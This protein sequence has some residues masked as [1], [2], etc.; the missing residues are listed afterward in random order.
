MLGAGHNEPATP[1]RS[2]QSSL[3]KPQLTGQVIGRFMTPSEI[4]ELI[5]KHDVR[6][7][8]LQFVDIGGVLHTLWIPVDLLSAVAEEGIHTDGSSLAGMV[9]V[10]K[11]DVKL[12]P[13]MGTFVVLPAQLFPERVARVVCDIYEPESDRP[14]ELDP[15][16][17]LRQA[18]NKARDTLG[19]DTGYY[20]ASEIEFFLLKRDQS[21]ELEL[22]DQGRYL[23]TP[24]ADRGADL[25]LEMAAALR[26]MGVVVEKHHHEV[27]HGK[28]EFNLQYSHAVHMADTIYLVKFLVKQMADQ[29]GL[30]ASFMPKPF[31][32][33]YGCGLHTHVSLIDDD[34][35]QNL[36]ADP[37]AD[38]GLSQTATHFLAG[39]LSHAR[40]LAGITNPSVNSYKR[41]V[42]GWEA[43]VNISW[44]RYNRSVLVRIPPGRG[45]GTRLEYRPTD[46]ACNFYLAFAC[47][48]AAGL[49][50]IQRKLE[51]PAPVEE[52]IYKMTAEERSRRGIEVL[53]GSLGEALAELSADEVLRTGLG[54][55]LMTRFLDLKHKEW[56]EFNTLV[57]AWERKK[58]LDV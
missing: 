50:G 12:I 20:T 14:F 17:V 22:V 27:P 4:E 55:P 44:A 32:G 31:H 52:D 46:G 3:W 47:I 11:S 7:I 38:L 45:R 5:R 37:N 21:G 40:A 42:P 41:L 24:P 49:D 18:I 36:F 53:P 10:S 28:N 26:S 19:P 15:R 33:E 6:T 56:H 13:D 30:V 8:A 51:P 39:M 48:L 25:R 57:H 2:R 43:P 16:Y 35:G 29:A 34:R 23:A 58:Y 1:G 9:D 54:S